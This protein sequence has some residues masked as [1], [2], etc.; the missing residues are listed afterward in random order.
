MEG[1]HNHGLHFGSSEPSSNG[2]FLGFQEM[3]EFL[4]RSDSQVTYILIPGHSMALC[5]QPPASIL[6]LARSL[7][8]C[9]DSCLS[10]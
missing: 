9:F 3:V 2:E 1:S 6:F 5:N 4:K 10:C 7:A 8:S